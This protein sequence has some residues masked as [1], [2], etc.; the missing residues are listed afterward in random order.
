[1]PWKTLSAMSQR[2]EFVS[3]AR[4]DGS[5]MA[6]LCER[7]GISRP[8]GYKWV[9]RGARDG[10]AGL[11]AL[12][13]RPHHSP[14]RT[15]DALE[16]AVVSV[17][18][19]HPAWGGRKIAQVLRNNGMEH[20]PAASTI[21][22]ILRRHSLIDPHEADKHRAWKRFEHALPN[23]L[24]QM[25]FKGHFALT[26]ARTRCHPLTILDDHSRFSIAIR[27]CAQETRAVVRMELIRVFRQYGMPLCMLCDNGP[28]WGMPAEYGGYTQLSVWLIR[29]G[30]HVSHGRPYH[31]QTQGKD[32]RFHRTLN[33]EVLHHHQ[34][35]SFDACQLAFDTW[36][37]VYNCER[38]NQGINMQTPVTR[39]QPSPRGFPEQL[40]PIEYGPD[41]LVRKVQAKGD[42]NFRGRILT[43]SKALKGQSVAVRPTNDDGVYGVY[44]CQQF[45]CEIDLREHSSTEKV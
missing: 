14:R 29:M 26:D 5:N 11:I 23:D 36:R 45:I 43:L 20:V 18:Q 27:A 24:W 39:Y 3:L 7:F 44:F 6:Q 22:D 41:D 12:S 16:A 21:T 33:A 31:P 35:D 28:P 25:D 37:D 40:P 42:I 32:E 2:K 34:L 10:D 38:P 1:M 13:R 8:T 9:Q 30:I 17:R 19:A 15:H 4:A